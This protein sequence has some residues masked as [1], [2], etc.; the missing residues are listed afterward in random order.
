M[1][2]WNLTYQEAIQVIEEQYTD[3]YGIIVTKNDDR[4]DSFALTNRYYYLRK[5]NEPDNTELDIKY[6]KVITQFELNKDRYIRHPDNQTPY[7]DGQLPQEYIADSTRFSRDQQ[8]PGV[9]CMGEYPEEKSRLERLYASHVAHGYQNKDVAGPQHWSRYIRSLGHKLSYPLL[10]LYD[11]AL[12]IDSYLNFWKRSDDE[13][14]VGDTINHS[15]A[16]IQAYHRYPTPLS[17]WARKVLK[18]S[19]PYEAWQIYFRPEAGSPPLDILIKKP[20]EDADLK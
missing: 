15:L 17:W 1:E 2:Y 10:V 18:K 3:K 19:N 11:A 12:L 4:G 5:L 7:K 9:I 16:I 20:M 6:S 13:G 14:D 8:D